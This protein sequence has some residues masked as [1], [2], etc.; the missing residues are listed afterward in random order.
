MIIFIA[1]FGRENQNKI[2]YL[3]Q[4]IQNR[5][6]IYSNSILQYWFHEINIKILAAN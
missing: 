1:S 2:E 6:E 4:S 5:V 3:Y